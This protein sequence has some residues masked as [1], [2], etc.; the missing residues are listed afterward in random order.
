MCNLVLQS[1]YV[2]CH[3]S[4]GTVMCVTGSCHPW[5]RSLSLLIGR[6][7]GVLPLAFWP[8]LSHDFAHHVCFAWYFWTMIS[9]GLK[10]PNFEGQGF[11]DAG[12]GGS[13]TAF[14]REGVSSV[15]L[16]H[17]SDSLIFIPG[18]LSMSPAAA[19]HFWIWKNVSSSHHLTFLHELGL[20]ALASAHRSVRFTAGVLFVTLRLSM[21][22]SSP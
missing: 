2:F 9:P 6:P 20:W 15:H 13:R 16:N 21:Y 14:F 3:K 17:L 12:S 11:H 1:T 19:S 5:P 8:W 22:S 4:L 7:Q 18:A 10:N